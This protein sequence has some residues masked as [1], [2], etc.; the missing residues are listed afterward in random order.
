[1]KKEGGMRDEMRKEEDEEG[2]RRQEEEGGGGG[3]G[4]RIK[5]RGRKEA[6]IIC[7]PPLT[8]IAV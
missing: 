4:R 2:G 3:A 5:E 1:M 8:P 7:V 6:E